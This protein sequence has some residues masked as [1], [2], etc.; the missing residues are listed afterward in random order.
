M[1]CLITG[2]AGFIGSHLADAL[3][4]R[5]D[6]VVAL[7]NLSTGSLENV[8][9][10]ESNSRFRLVTGSILDEQVVARL[11]PD[12][13]IVFHLAAAVGVKWIIEKPLDSI[14]TNV[15]GTEIV[16]EQAE[17]HKK[18]TLVA[19]TSEV[20]GK[21][22]ACPP[23]SRTTRADGMVQGECGRVFG[24][25]GVLN[26]EGDWLLGATSITR[27]LYATTKACDEF[28]ALAYCREKGLPVVITRFFNTVGPRQT[29]EYGM[30]VPRFVRQALS[31]QP[32]TVHG[33][34]Q[35]SRCF[36]DVSDAVRCILALSQT[37]EAEGRVVNVGSDQEIT[38]EAL[39]RRVI[40]MTGSRSEVAFVPYDQVYDKGFEDMRR[41]VPD[42]DRLSAL[43]GFRPCT[44]LEVTLQ[45]VIE[46]HRH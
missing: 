13:D 44:P 39:A 1:R 3:L 43:V 37:P 23:Q 30:V 6:E 14:Q 19:S 28:L 46:F 38:I 9:H 36:T 41:R 25:K 42:L 2:G 21:N 7:D 15:R 22:G 11:V 8:R 35:Q 16:L 34:G 33:D 12:C 32:L 40:A 18:K 27:W 5:G 20:Y 31:G 29:G 10:L 17:R 26:E 45:R 4:A 24:P